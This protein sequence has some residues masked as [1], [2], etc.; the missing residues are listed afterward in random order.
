VRTSV[1]GMSSPIWVAPV[2]KFTSTGAS[3]F[4]GIFI[5]RVP[6]IPSVSIAF[7]AVSSANKESGRRAACVN[8]ACRSALA[9]SCVKCAPPNRAPVRTLRTKKTTPMRA[10]A[11]VWEVARC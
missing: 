6:E 3:F 7:A 5:T 11:G 4:R 8:I 1:H 2:V 9:S 10:D